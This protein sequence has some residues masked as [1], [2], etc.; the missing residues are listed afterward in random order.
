MPAQLFLCFNFAF[1]LDFTLAGIGEEV[2]F[3]SFDSRYPRNRNG[4]RTAFLA[5]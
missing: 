1:G 2:W 4:L 3:G 5:W